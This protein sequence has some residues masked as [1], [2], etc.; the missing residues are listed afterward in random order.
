MQRNRDERWHRLLVVGVR[1][2]LDAI[3][4]DAPHVQANVSGTLVL[5]PTHSSADVSEIQR[6]RDD[7]RVG[8]DELLIEREKERET[9]A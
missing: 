7:F 8:G 1:V 4:K 2:K 9:K 3:G 6:T 5:A